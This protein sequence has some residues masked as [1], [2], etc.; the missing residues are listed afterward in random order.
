MVVTHI[1]Q[2]VIVVL[3]VVLIRRD[4]TVVHPNI[5]GFF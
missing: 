3:V 2:T 5:G 4:I 1:D